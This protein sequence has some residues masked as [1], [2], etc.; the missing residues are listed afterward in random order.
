MGFRKITQ[1]SPLKLP[2]AEVR[3][4]ILHWT[5]ARYGQSFPDYHFLIDADGTVY[6]NENAPP[7]VWTEHTWHRNTGNIGIAAEAMLNATPD[8]YG[9]YSY[10][11]EQLEAICALAAKIAKKYGIAPIN[12]LTHAE[13]AAQD[14]YGPGSGD[15]ETRW[16]WWHEGEKIHQKIAWYLKQ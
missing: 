10:T 6:Q 15:P 13:A 12:I 3:G 5:A 7:G 2:P 4:I 11:R 9:S 14:G 16:D 8:N 1:S